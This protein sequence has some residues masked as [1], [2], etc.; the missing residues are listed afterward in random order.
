MP[1]IPLHSYAARIKEMIRNDHHDEA[2][3]HCQHI[4]RQYP[5]HVETYCLLGEAC[6]EKELYRSAIECFQR[7]LGADPE[8]LISRVGL[9]II[10]GEQGM[11][12]EAIWHMERAFELAPGNTEVR[13]ELQ[14]LYTQRDSVEKARLKLTPGALGRLYARNGLYERAITEFRSLLKEDPNLPDI[15]VALAEALWHDGR[16]LEAV[17]VCLDLLSMLPNCLKANLILGE[18]WMRGGNEDAGEEKLNI[19]RALDPE[20]LVAQGMMGKDS[21]LPPQEVLI[22]EL[23]VMPARPWIMPSA[24][25]MEIE[26]GAEEEEFVSEAPDW[27]QELERE[28]QIP[29]L[30]I[31]EAGVGLEAAVEEATPAEEIPEWLRELGLIGAE[32]E[33]FAEAQVQVEEAEAE[34]AELGEEALP[35]EEMAEELLPEAELA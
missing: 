6:L 23:E 1:E 24:A 4:L 7:A 30:P 28:E 15:R 2:I 21:P 20:N 13:R 32:E 9:G 3:A 27:V 19:A 35:E 25:E 17:D 22:P 12:P 31:E 33:A 8:N 18:I 11:L 5:K 29:V 10:T 26:R 34:I 14:R 16:R